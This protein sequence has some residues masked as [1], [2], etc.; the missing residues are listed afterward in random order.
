MDILK[1]KQYKSY[2][3]LCRYTSFPYYYNM[4]DLKYIYGTTAQLNNNTVYTIHIVKN[5]DTWDT[6]ALDYYNN[7]TLFWVICDFNRVQD[8]YTKPTV[9]DKIKIPTLNQISYGDN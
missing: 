3:Y 8:P 1:D 2:N 7:P 9:G 4:E 6:I 5:G